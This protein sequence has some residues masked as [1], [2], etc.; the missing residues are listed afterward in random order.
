MYAPFIVRVENQVPE[1]FVQLDLVSE[2]GKYLDAQ[3]VCIRGKN[4]PYVRVDDVMKLFENPDN[5]LL[6][7]KAFKLIPECK[8]LALEEFETNGPESFGEFSNN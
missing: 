6:Y 5:R 7:P 1:V 8:K 2:I 3:N 4:I